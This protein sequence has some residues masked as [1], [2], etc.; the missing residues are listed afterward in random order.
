MTERIRFADENARIAWKTAKDVERT[1]MG[2]PEI[3]SEDFFETRRITFEDKDKLRGGW[4]VFFAGGEALDPSEV[5]IESESAE[6]EDFNAEPETFT[7]SKRVVNILDAL[8][9]PY[10]T[11]PDNT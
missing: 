6:G 4:A 11:I 10:Q 5:G 9:I 7:I 1:I 8:Q 3:E 2:L